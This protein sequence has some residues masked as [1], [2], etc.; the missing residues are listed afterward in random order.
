MGNKLAT[1]RPSEGVKWCP[2]TTLPSPGCQPQTSS[3]S[4]GDAEGLSPEPDAPA[5]E[6]SR[7]KKKELSLA[8]YLR[9]R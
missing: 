4:T 6:E 3:G 7:G 1:D 8:V 2:I 9:S 5:A